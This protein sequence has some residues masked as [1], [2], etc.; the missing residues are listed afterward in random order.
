MTYEIKGNWKK[1]FAL[2]LHTES[3]AYLGLDEFGHDRFKTKRTEIGEY[4]YKLKYQFDLSVLPKIVSFI[5]SK[6]SNI[7]KVDFIIPVPP[8]NA[9]R[10]VQP[11][12]EVAY[13]LGKDVKVSV[14]PDAVIKTKPTPELKNVSDPAERDKIL[15]NAFSI[16]SKYNFGSKNILLIDDLFRS[17][18][19]FRSITRVL[20]DQG[21]AKNVF[22]VAL[23]KTRSK[24]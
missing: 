5:T 15:S 14:L 17:G 24:R 21:K 6:I 4:V 16:S 1:G 23:T 19:T 13:A 12:F 8:S 18:A 3:S 7:H 10:K 9:S 22:V 2:D 20:Y 11:V